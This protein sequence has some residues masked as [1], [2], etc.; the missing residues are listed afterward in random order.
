MI[1]RASISQGNHRGWCCFNFVLK[2]PASKGSLLPGRDRKRV[3]PTPDDFTAPSVTI[4][5]L[6]FLLGMVIDLVEAKLSFAELKLSNADSVQAIFSA[7][8]ATCS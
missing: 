3:E 1:E 5:S 2:K 6:S 8:L 4:H 7:D